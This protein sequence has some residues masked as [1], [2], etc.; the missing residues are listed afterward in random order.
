MSDMI[1][2]EIARARGHRI[3]RCLIDE[4][5]PDGLLVILCHRLSLVKK[6]MR[7]SMGSIIFGQVSKHCRKRRFS[8]VL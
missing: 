3:E 4:L 5:Q 8:F 6:T 2:Y 7:S 1:R